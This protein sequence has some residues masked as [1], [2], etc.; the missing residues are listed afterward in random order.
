MNQEKSKVPPAINIAGILDEK[1]REKESSITPPESKARGVL[2]LLDTNEKVPVG[3]FETIQEKNPDGYIVGVGV[4]NVFSLLNCFQ[5]RNPPR[6][7][8]LVDIDPRVVTIGKILVDSL[9]QAETPSDFVNDFFG[10][11]KDKL[12]ARIRETISKEKNVVLRQRLE[13]IPSQEWERTIKAVQGWSF[14][15]PDFKSGVQEKE[16]YDGAMTMINKFDVFREMAR[17]NNIAVIC[18]DFTNLD[19]I[20][21]IQDLPGFRESRNIIYM[22]N[23]VDHIA[24]PQGVKFIDVWNKMESLVAYGRESHKSIFIDTLQN[25]NYFLRVGYTMPM[26]EEED[27]EFRDV[28]DR[29]NAPEG[30]IFGR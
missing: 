22:S 16:S 10:L 6:G 13:K 12:E 8:V 30:L 23:I 4:G 20:V 2:A 7:M 1:L 9:K 24:R 26:Y 19:L 17:S 15:T 21:S 27:V 18:S 14:L 5:E 3:F 25:L 29:S 11:P 28:K